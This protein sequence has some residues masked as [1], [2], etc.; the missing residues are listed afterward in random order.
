M[1]TVVSKD[2]TEL[3]V[4]VIGEGEPVVLLAHG[5][6]GNRNELAIFAPFIPGT[7]VLMDF[8]GHGNS[9]RPPEGSYSFD[10]LAEDVR[11]VADEFGVTV[12]AGGSMGAAAT[13][14]VLEHDPARFEKLIILLPAKLEVGD[15]TYVR[16]S[17]MADLLEEHGPERTAEIVLAEEEAAGA[18]EQFPAS[19]DY[20]QAAILAMNSDGVPRAIRGVI[21]DMPVREAERLRDVKAPTLIITQQGDAFHSV[22]VATELAELMP[23][24]DLVILPDQHALLRE[25]PMLITKV[26][27][28]LSS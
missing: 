3:F 19:K 27:Q 13:L 22:Q 8:R 14:R 24:T 17:R 2:G 7:K 18:F 26:H 5:L 10:F 28:L 25:I 15:E 4:E 12:V 6:T 21:N 1:P 11:A 20:R 16:L 23:N 9:G